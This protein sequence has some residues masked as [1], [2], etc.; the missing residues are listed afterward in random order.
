[1]NKILIRKTA[2][3]CPF[4]GKKLRKYEY[5]TPIRQSCY[6]SCPACKREYS[7]SI[8]TSNKSYMINLWWKDGDTRI[9]DAIRRAKKKG[10]K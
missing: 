6:A 1:M 5:N 4:C 9:I 7:V 8:V 3:F 10:L 2:L